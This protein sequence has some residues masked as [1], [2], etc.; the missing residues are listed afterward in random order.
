LARKDAL[1]GPLCD[2]A[3]AHAVDVVLL[4]ECESPRDVE[5]A[6]NR[7]SRLYHWVTSPAT[8]ALTSPASKVQ[9]FTAFSRALT[10]YREDGGYHTAVELE[11]P[12]AP[13]SLL[14]VGVHFRSL[15]HQRT[16]SQQLEATVLAGDIRKLEERV[17][18]TRTLVIGDL[19][20]DPFDAGVVGA[21]GLHAVAVAEVASRGSR[22]VGRRSYD[23]FYNPTWG[24]MSDRQ[25]GPPGTFFRKSSEQL[26]YFWHS[27][28]QV[29]L[30][31]SLISMFD[32]ADGLRILE[33]AGAV[34][35]VTSRG[36]PSVSDHLP[37]LLSLNQ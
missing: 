26:S 12:G 35:L 6:L 4:A 1:V 24:H 16:D 11:P 34:S 2:I 28:D 13:L 17:G 19:N 10:K 7:T 14:L 36:R 32:K 22:T 20:M 33:T 27:L 8:N 37:L 21:T 29:L 25:S 23:F 15:L 31:P 18:H 5:L 9:I 3:R 30:R